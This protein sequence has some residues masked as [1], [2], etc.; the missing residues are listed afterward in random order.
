MSKKTYSIITVTYNSEHQI[1]NLLNSLFKYSDPVEVIV[2][3][4]NSKDNSAEIVS[5]FKNVKLMKLSQNIGFSKANNLAAKVA[6]G[7]YLVFV[8]PDT[9]FINKDTI[10]KLIDDLEN[11]PEYGLVGPLLIH[12]DQTIQITVRNLPTLKRAFNEYIMNRKGEYDFYKPDA[13][14]LCPVETIVGAGMVIKKTLF[15]QIGGFSEKFFLYYEDID[16]CRKILEKGLKVGYDPTAQMNH[17]EGA[18]TKSKN[19]LPFGLRTLSWFIPMKSSGSRYY[20]IQSTQIYHGFITA[21]LLRILMYAK[22]KY[23]S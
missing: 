14:Q 10:E 15:L 11:N 19:T 23:A 2:V 20:M 5:K 3:D 6:K 16:L 21:F 1:S 22:A 17:V 9:R 4:N 7:E 12:D 18:S 13:N 8:N